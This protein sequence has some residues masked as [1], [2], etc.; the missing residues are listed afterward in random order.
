[1]P[2][3]QDTGTFTNAADEQALKDIAKAEASGADPFGDAE[4]DDKPAAA[5]ADEDDTDDDTP[6]EATAAAAADA[7]DNAADDEPAATPAAAESAAED[8]PAPASD[9][10]YVTPT[11]AAL[12]QKA[13]EL[14]VREEKAFADFD[15]GTIT[16]EAYQE[17]Q[18]AFRTEN[19]ALAAETAL[20]QAN[21]QQLQRTQQAKLGEIKALAKTQGL[22]YDADAD[23]PLEFDAALRFVASVPKNAN[24]SYAE[25]ADKAHATVLAQRGITPKPA[26]APAP[27]AKPR[28]AA[29]PPPMT[30]AR[31]PAAATANTN[32]GVDEQL[33][34]L[35]GLEFEAAIGGMSKAKRDAWMDA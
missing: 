11:R 29:P 28:V 9:D 8:A 26:A 30:L 25:L 32:G 33:S 14:A 21:E 16:R 20:L 12:D 17:L 13:E 31:V 1:M 2:K 15:E 7:E 22:D 10:L 3:K 35:H 24:L 18:R 19:R 6:D 4:F 34:R 23:A 27:G 5:L